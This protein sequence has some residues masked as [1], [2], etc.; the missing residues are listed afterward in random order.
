MRVR[1]VAVAF[2][3]AVAA[4]ALGAVWLIRNPVAFP[5]AARPAPS[6][7][8]TRLRADVEAL[9]AIR[10]ARNANHP[11]SMEEAARHIARGFAAAGCSPRNQWFE[12]AGATFRNVFCRMG[13]PGAPRVVIGAHY[14]VD[15]E[16]NP[17]ADDNASGVA[18]VLEL[19]RMLAAA[20]PALDHRLELAAYALEEMPHHRSPA[21]GSHAHAAALAADGAAVQVMVSVEMI[22][23]YSQAEGSQLYPLAPL[24]WLYP[25]RADFIGVVGRTLDRR[26]VARVK[27][28]MRATGGLPAYSINAPTWIPGIDFSDHWSF[29]EH[30]MAAVMVTDTA[31][32][33]NPHYHGPG[34][35]PETLDYRRMA[36]A[37][38]GLYQVAIGY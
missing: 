22:G 7:E 14:D 26:A 35:T 24:R 9:A 27:G 20:R 11:E 36:Q 1:K 30:G 13:P 15:G 25:A 29:W 8:P 33:R 5:P 31:F 10:P 3:L 18:A 2:L 12:A 21:M 4:L 28:L 19:A 32:Y 6:A 38:D 23:Y 34:D 17:G 16:N 37:V